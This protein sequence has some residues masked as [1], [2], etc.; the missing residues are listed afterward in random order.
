[1]IGK[2]N[3]RFHDRE[4]KLTLLFAVLYLQNF[5]ESCATV[6][7][8]NGFSSHRD[9]KEKPEVGDPTA[10]QLLDIG[11]QQAHLV[12]STRRITV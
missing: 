5:Q 6:T 4:S 7:L 8:S 11:R 3:L 2:L 1:M 10:P 9:K 12:M